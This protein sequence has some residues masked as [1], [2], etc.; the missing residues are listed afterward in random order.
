VQRRRVLQLLLWLLFVGTLLLQTTVQ[1][2]Q[3]IGAKAA[4]L[5]AGSL[6]GKCL[7]AVDA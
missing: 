3:Q 6:L 2:G 4:E 5:V 7:T 1:H